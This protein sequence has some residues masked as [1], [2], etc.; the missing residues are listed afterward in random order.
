[1]KKEFAEETMREIQESKII[2]EKNLN[3]NKSFIESKE[4]KLNQEKEKSID[5]SRK[6]SEKI[7]EALVL[8]NTVGGL[9][10]IEKVLREKI[11]KLEEKR[12]N[13]E[14]QLET[15]KNTNA[16]LEKRIQ[17]LEKKPSLDLQSQ[18]NQNGILKKEYTKRSTGLILKKNSTYNFV[19]FSLGAIDDLK[20]GQILNVFREKTIIGKIRV[21]KVFDNVSSAVILQKTFSGKVPIK[22]DTV[23]VF[24]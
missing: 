17:E 22:G 2:L 18:L 10:N 19:L 6:L 20:K 1:M 8:K 5:V 9:K 21:E 14:S 24:R 4:K 3:S 13:L 15:Q 7:N 16:D 12:D 23:K 11:E